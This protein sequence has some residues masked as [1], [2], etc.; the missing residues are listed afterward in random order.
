[1]T[2]I[3]LLAIAS[4]GC[5]T[6]RN[7]PRGADAPSLFHKSMSLIKA[8]TDSMMLATDSTRVESLANGLEERLTKLNFSYPADTDLQLTE[9]ENDTLA[10][11]TSKFVKLKKERLYQFAHPIVRTDSDSIARQRPAVADTVSHASGA[12][13]NASNQTQR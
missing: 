3:F 7:N 5:D 9:G 13:R 10:I 2:A 12:S 1:M 4:M 8:Y 6:G 11:V